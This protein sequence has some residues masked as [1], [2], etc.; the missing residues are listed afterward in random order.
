MPAGYLLLGVALLFP[1]FG[2][3]IG[4]AD[5]DSGVL[6]RAGFGI[7]ALASALLVEALWYVRPWVA[8]AADAWA[9]ACCGA[10]LLTGLAAAIVDGVSAGIVVGTAVMLCFVAVPC[11]GVRWYVRDRARRLGLAPGFV[12]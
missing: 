6:L 11:G 12:P 4:V 1:S 7:V 5:V 10:V 2:F 8:R 3:T 9:A